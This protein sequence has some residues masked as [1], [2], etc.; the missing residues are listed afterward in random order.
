[1]KAKEIAQ[2]VIDEINK[3]KALQLDKSEE[4]EKILTQLLGSLPCVGECWRIDCGK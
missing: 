4:T 3:V 2:I 1:M